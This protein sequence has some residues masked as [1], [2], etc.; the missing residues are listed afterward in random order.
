[1]SSDGLTLAVAGM[2]NSQPLLMNI[3]PKDGSFNNFISLDYN[4]GASE[5]LPQYVHF[6]GIYYD[7]QDYS[8]DQSYF[9]SAFIKDGDMFMLRVAE[10]D[11]AP[12]ID[13]NYRFINYSDA[14]ELANPLINMKE[15][16][17]IVPDPKQPSALYMIGSYRGKG[18]VI[19]FNKED[20][21]VSWKAQYEQISSI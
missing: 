16:N 13:W 14:E 11:G 8:N 12:E 1:M 17:F 5:D 7:K 21:S 3:N 20:G 19:H 6:G 18:S 15:P 9:Y 10:G 2:G 4:D